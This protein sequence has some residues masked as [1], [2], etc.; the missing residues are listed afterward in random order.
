[1]PPIEPPDSKALPLLHTPVEEGE[2]ISANAPLFT[3]RWAG[4]FA[5]PEPDPEDA[6]V[7]YLLERYESSSQ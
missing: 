1:M 4:E 7:S 5:L 3:T 2:K 6:R